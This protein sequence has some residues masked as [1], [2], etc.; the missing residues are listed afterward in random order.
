MYISN[1]NNVAI[2]SV[3]DLRRETKKGG[4]PVR[5]KVT[6]KGI[7]R[8]YPT[9]E[10][11]SEI[12][13]KSLASSKTRSHKT[14]KEHIE[15]TFNIVKANVELLTKENQFTFE[16]LDTLMDRG[17]RNTL[18]EFI[19]YKIEYFKNL[20]HSGSMNDL[21]Y[22][23]NS[24]EK[25]SGKNINPKD[26]N[27]DW[28]KRYESSLLTKG[29]NY[30]TVG[31]RMRALRTIINLMK[32]KRLITE[33]QYPFGKDKYKI[34]TGESRK[35]A[36]NDE[37]LKAL[38]TIDEG[39]TLANRKYLDIW[40]LCYYCNG[41]NVIDLL[42]LRYSNIHGS[43]IFFNRAKTLHTSKHK[44]E[45]GISIKPRITDILKRWGNPNDGKDPYLLPF[46]NGCT[47]PVKERKIVSQATSNINDHMKKICQKLGIT[48][49][50]TTYTARHT[51]ATKMLRG[52]VST[53]FI[54]NSL[55]HTDVRT[56]EAYLAGFS[57]EERAKFADLLDK[58]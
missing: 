26:I 17:E 34:P 8:H 46:L 37:Q 4:Y 49:I 15:N 24:I 14:A 41:I 47:N 45:I 39:L 3:I 56:T 31:M 21:V 2:E 55:G 48:E 7:R 27:V 25:F 5:I 40:I 36:L 54:Q 35:M 16:A 11:L 57:K 32:E 19:D 22:F 43:E 28:V 29:N 13:W 58:F 42:R 30:T 10:S 20:G 38:L 18:N 12:E 9:G 52:G 23:K 51:F 44:K 50:I 6:F 33:D 53:A 1:T